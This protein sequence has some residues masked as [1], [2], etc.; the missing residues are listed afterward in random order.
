MRPSAEILVVDDE[1][2][3]CSLIQDGL[4]G[5]GLRCTTANDPRQALRAMAGGRFRVVVADVSMP[6]GGGLALLEDARRRDG[7]C[8]VILI[9]GVPSA[10]SLARALALG[11]YDYFPKPFDIDELIA[12]VGQAAAARSRSTALPMK[13]AQALQKQSQIR[14]HSLETIR[15]LVSAVEAKDSYTRWHSEQVAYYAVHLCQFLTLDKDVTELVR[16]ASLLHDV[17]KIGTPDAVLTKPGALSRTE[18][19]HIRRHPALGAQILEHMSMLTRE[20]EIVRGH[21]ENY[22]GSGY[23]E[24]LMGENIPLGARI[25]RVADSVDAML[26]RRTYKA[27]Y[28]IAHVREQ[29]AAGGGKEFDPDLTEAFQAWMIRHPDLLIRPSRS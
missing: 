26:M 19:Q 4:V 17:G 1:P 23:P 29:L 3:V 12:S 11:A 21:H 10:E 16:V 18:F 22:D 15:A 25:I 8:R 6:Y 7:D 20:A 13:A 24:G 5:A 27:P 9:T 2:Q 14:Q 28:S